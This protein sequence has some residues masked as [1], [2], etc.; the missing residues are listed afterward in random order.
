MGDP[1]HTLSLGDAANAPGFS[2]LPRAIFLLHRIERATHSD[3]SSRLEVSQS[4]VE[5]AI[6]HVLVNLVRMREG[7]PL[8]PC[9]YPEVVAAEVRLH[10]TFQTEEAAWRDANASNR[11]GLSRSLRAWGGTTDFDAWLWHCVTGC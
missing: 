3:I 4:V 1:E 5:S 2:P 11:L 8:Q 10:S 9:I 7:R 6:A